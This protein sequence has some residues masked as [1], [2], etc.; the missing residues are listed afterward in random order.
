MQGRVQRGPVISRQR[1]EHAVARW[2]VGSTAARSGI[3]LC[4]R[5]ADAD[6]A[7]DSLSKRFLV[8]EIPFVHGK[9][10]LAGCAGATL[11]SAA[12][13]LASA[14]RAGRSNCAATS[15]ARPTCELGGCWPMVD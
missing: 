1:E 6:T 13:T 11:A 5:V 10:F 12:I 4:V 14:D 15:A 3:T 2:F 7:R 9:R 8:Q